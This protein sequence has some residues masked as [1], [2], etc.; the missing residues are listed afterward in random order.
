MQ[1]CS[2][3]RMYR[4]SMERLYN[5]LGPRNFLN[6][7]ARAKMPVLSRYMHLSISF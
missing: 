3:Q 6:R 1:Y 4:R 2:Q 5:G 7:V